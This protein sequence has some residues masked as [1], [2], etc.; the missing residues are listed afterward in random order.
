VCKKRYSC[1]PFNVIIKRAQR[2]A[3]VYV[4]D[5]ST[6]S[7]IYLTLQLLYF[8]RVFKHINVGRKTPKSSASKHCC[9]SQNDVYRNNI[10]IYIYIYCSTIIYSLRIRRHVYRCLCVRNAFNEIKLVVY[11]L[12]LIVR[13]GTRYHFVLINTRL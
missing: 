9:K 4:L 3:T 8:Y 7:S 2:C 12:V 1:N 5:T 6:F 13:R 10:H 11:L